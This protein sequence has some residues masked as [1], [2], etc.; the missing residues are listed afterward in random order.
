MQRLFSITLHSE[1]NWN[2]KRLVPHRIKIFRDN[3][4]RPSLLPHLQDNVRVA[5]AAWQQRILKKKNLKV[6]VRV[7][8]AQRILES[9]CSNTLYLLYKA[10]IWDLSEIV[11]IKSH[12]KRD[13]SEITPV[14][15]ST[16]TKNLV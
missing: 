4:C 11:P 7:A 14:L 15:N 9:Q 3:S 2:L 1:P 5:C 6:N 13:F 16:E 8:C 12:Y 10:T